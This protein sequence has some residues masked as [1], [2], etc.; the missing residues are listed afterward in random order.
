MLE[1]LFFSGN[2]D[3]PESLRQL[4]LQEGLRKYLETTSRAENGGRV[5]SA[6]ATATSANEV[7][8]GTT[9]HSGSLRF[10]ALY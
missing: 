6:N 9:I 7:K 4:E 8:T 3:A 1:T 2:V 10:Q 5:M